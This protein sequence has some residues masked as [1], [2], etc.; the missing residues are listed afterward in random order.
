MSLH[1]LYRAMDF[2]EDHKKEIEEALY[3]RLADLFNMDV[4]LIFY[5]TTSV[6]G[7]TWPCLREELRS[8]KIGQLL[9]PHGTVY[10]TSPGSLQA[11]NLL[12]KLKIDPLPSVLAVE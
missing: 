5:D 8:I 1:H 3:R 4:D 2:L 7:D 10:Q 9:A 6:L 11:R 12:K